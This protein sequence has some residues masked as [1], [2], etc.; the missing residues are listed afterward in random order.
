M[1]YFIFLITL[2]C[3]S[4]HP[5]H[6]PTDTVLLE[7]VST[8]ALYQTDIFRQMIC[9]QIFFDSPPYTKVSLKNRDGTPHEF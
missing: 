2:D 8:M 6:I 4:S 1:A 5:P 7:M 9:V 3:P